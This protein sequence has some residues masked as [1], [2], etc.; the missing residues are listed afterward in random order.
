VGFEVDGITI[1]S[2]LSLIAVLGALIVRVLRSELHDIIGEAVRSHGMTLAISMGAAAL[3]VE[4]SYY[5]V[6][7]VLKREGIDLWGMHPA[8]ELLSLIVTA[9][10]YVMM[11]PIIFAGSATRNGAFRRIAIDVI[12]IAL[13][14]ATTALV[15]A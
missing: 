7:R 2:H 3:A 8:P 1:A 12:A 9:G 15:L 13:F 10:V 14:F 11:V 4:R 5:V 6:A